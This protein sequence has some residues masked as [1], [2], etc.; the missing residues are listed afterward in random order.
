MIPKNATPYDPPKL[1]KN[2]ASQEVFS[3]LS[4]MGGLTAGGAQV[5]VQL[6][7]NGGPHRR[8]LSS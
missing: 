4:E 8:G 5:G 7:S 3:M 2:M 1:H 6:R